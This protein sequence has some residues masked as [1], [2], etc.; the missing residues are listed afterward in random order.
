MTRT[1]ARLI[2]VGTAI[3]LVAVLLFYRPAVT[4]AP[5]NFALLTSDEQTELE[6]NPT[7]LERSIGVTNTAGPLIKVSSP[8]GFS[9]KSPVDFDIVVE[10]QDG[11]P[12]DMQSIRIEYKIGPAWINVTNRI[13]QYASIKGSRLFATGAELPSGNHALRVSVSDNKKRKTQAVVTFKV[14]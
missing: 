6:K 9:L 4:P 3:V 13:L 8:S 5:E 1:K 10:P 2:L 14:D 11:A 7:K 12:V